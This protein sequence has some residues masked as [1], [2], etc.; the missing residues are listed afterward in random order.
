MLLVY[1]SKTTNVSRLINR[2][3]QPYFKQ[4]R[5]T[6]DLIVDEPVILITYTTGMGEVPN[7][8]YQFCQNNHL[9]LQYVMASGNRNWGKLFARS[10]DL[11]EDQFGAKLLYKFELS[12]NRNDLYNINVH[13]Q[14]I[15][16]SLEQEKNEISNQLEQFRK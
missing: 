16:S 15:Y 12:G 9:F 7:E 6:A 11:I 1:F 8:V 13:L 5:G 3:N 10:G 4:V 2:L 14:N